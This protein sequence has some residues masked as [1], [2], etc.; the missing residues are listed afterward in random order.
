MANSNDK[1]RNLFKEILGSTFEK[2]E[3]DENA[4]FVQTS[5]PYNMCDGSGYIIEFVNEKKKAQDCKCVK[6]EIV[7]RKLRNSNMDDAY[8]NREL[9]LE[10]LEGVLLHPLANPP[11]RQLQKGKNGAVLKVQ[12]PESPQEY[13]DRCYKQIQ[14][15]NGLEAFMKEYTTRT[16]EFVGEEPRQK[17]KNLI[18]LGDTGR[19]KTYIA[20]MAGKE[21]LMN[22]KR[23][24]FTTMRT[25][26][27]DV[28]NPQKDIEKI[29][30]E[31]DLLLIDELGYE[32][33]T[34]TGW[35]ITQ[36]KE[37][38]RVRYNK[39]LPVVC[40]TNLYPSD[41]SELY[42]KSLMS[43]FH[44]TYFMVFV[45]RVDGDYRIQQADEALKDFDSFN[46]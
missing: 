40:T 36:I 43:L 13:I 26:V 37:L 39:K 23:V 35:A 16:L 34:D 30:S 8:W 31:V 4:S 6:D 21:Y 24:Y 19:G 41:I 22:G 32:Y 44:G 18:L 33:H 28:I 5:C 17:V 11:E 12:E 15:K 45:D 1:V 3:D 9:K 20:N 10:G 27:K 29:V 38:L 46:I 2:L 42:D 7:R 14:M 25:L